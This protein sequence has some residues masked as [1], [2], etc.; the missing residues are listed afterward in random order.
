MPPLPRLTRSLAAS[1]DFQRRTDVLVPESAMLDLPER[2]VQFG[3]GALLRGF[4]DHF[5]DAA[6][7]RGE[8]NGRI[9]AIGSTGSGRDAS[10]NEQDGLFTLLISGIEDGTRREEARVIASVSRALSATDEWDRVLECARNP[11]LRLIFSN[12]T[13]VGITLDEGDQAAMAPPR[14][15]PGKLTAF[16]HARA[17]AFDFD[18]ARGVIVLPCELIESNGDR[19]REIVTELATRWNLG[20]DF[21]RWLESS[22]TF[23]NTLVDRIVPG[24]PAPERRA[25]IERTLGYR[26]ELATTCESYRLFAIEGDEAVKA[27]LG[28]AAADSG[29][30]VAESIAPYRLRKVRLLNGTHTIMAP[31]A[32]LAGCETV[33]DAMRHEVVSRFVRRAM[34]DEI[35]P[36]LDVP[37]AAAFARETLDRFA[38]PSIRHALFDITLHASMKMRVRIVPTILAYSERTGGAPESLAFGF[39][40]YLLFMRGELQRARKEAGMAVPPDDGRD[41][42]T[43]A[44]HSAGGDH[45]MLAR[46]V[47]A[48][49]TLW[50]TDL[51]AVSEFADSVA[52]HLAAIDRGG[53]AA[54]LDAHLATVSAT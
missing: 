51:T 48:D 45:R 24:T 52:E 54:A 38:N 29:I 14:S 25:E 10:V 11:E 32:L 28:F 43:S 46:S 37:S 23:C 49:A 33:L 41:R 4:V 53:A 16:L 39:A 35:V 17:L 26:D 7:R 3:T 21:P 13:E 44:W 20:D 1:P 5:I 2:A 36:T 9:V 31:L 50:G 12:T 30:V 8:F 27:R 6:N 40:A 47:C 15:F 42:I 34:L 19:L 22:V 18:P